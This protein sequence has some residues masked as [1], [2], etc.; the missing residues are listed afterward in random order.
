LQIEEHYGQRCKVKNCGKANIIGDFSSIN[1]S[2]NG[3][4]ASRRDKRYSKGN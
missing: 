1:P 2:L 3:T 4:D